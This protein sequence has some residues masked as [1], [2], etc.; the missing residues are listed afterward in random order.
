MSTEEPEDDKLGYPTTE[1]C[2]NCGATGDNF[3]EP[4]FA[5]IFC[6]KCKDIPPVKFGKHH[7]RPFE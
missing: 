6:L 5:Y 2:E 3:V 1:P 4:R 7:A